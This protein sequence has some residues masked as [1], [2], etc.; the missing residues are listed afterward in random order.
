MAF[1]TR[2]KLQPPLRRREFLSKLLDSGTE[3]DLPEVLDAILD[4][5]TEDLAVRVC[6]HLLAQIPPARLIR[7]L[8]WGLP[9][10]HLERAQL[11]RVARFKGGRSVLAV[12]TFHD[13]GYIRELAVR[14]LAGFPPE[15]WELPYFI[16]RLNDWVPQVRHAAEEAVLGLGRWPVNVL[17]DWDRLRQGQR[18]QRFAQRWQALLSEQEGIWQE[19]SVHSDRAVRRSAFLLGM[20]SGRG[21]GALLEALVDPDMSLVSCGLRHSKN[22]PGFDWRPWLD[23]HRTSIRLAAYKALQHELE[24]LDWLKALADPCWRIQQLAGQHLPQLDLAAH[25]RHQLPTLAAVRGLG[26]VGN[27]SDIERLR[28]LLDCCSSRLVRETIRSITRLAPE[29]WEEV[30]LRFLSDP[31]LDGAQTNMSSKRKNRRL[32]LGGGFCKVPFPD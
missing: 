16:P 14:S 2:L 22:F 18:N 25:Y 23:S 20:L 1:T 19:A 8:S 10:G 28:P 31:G 3:D 6:Q 9:W 30:W 5:E 27:P 17:P 26:Q 13:N 32:G 29:G 4:R 11:L 21:H 12:A 24:E 15:G 7:R